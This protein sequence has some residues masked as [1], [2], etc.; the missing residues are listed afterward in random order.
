MKISPFKR[1]MACL[2]AGVAMVAAL[3]P[4]NLW[5]FMFAGFSSFYMLLS[6]AKTPRAAFAIGWLF[7]FGYFAAGL[8]WI[9]NALLVEGNPFAWVWPLAIAGLPAL[10][11]IFPALAA[12]VC[13]R[14]TDRMRLEGFLCFVA[15]FAFSEWLRGHIF[16][17][18]PW[19]LYGYAWSGWLAMAQTASVGGSYFLTLLT[20][21]WCALPGFVAV[22]AISRP[23]KKKLLALGIITFAA[24]A[25]YG[26]FRLAQTGTAYDSTVTLRPVQPNIS[27]ADKW[28]PH[29]VAENLRKMLALSAPDADKPEPPLT[30]IV[31]PETALE[32]E[33]LANED[34]RSLIRQTL[35]QYRNTVYLVTG[36]L[37]YEPEPGGKG[38]YFNSLAVL[39]RDLNIR[40]MFSKSHLVPFGEYIPYQDIIPMKPFVQFQ[41]F[42]PGDG[43]ATLTVDGVPP[44]SPLICYEVVFPGAVTAKERPA[45]MVNVT[46]DAWYGDSPGPR[47]HLAQTRFRAIEEGLPLVRSA[48]T[49]ISG[50]IDPLGRIIY[51]AP[52]NTKDARDISLPKP[53]AGT[54]YASLRDSLFF[55]LLLLSGT[56]AYALERKSRA[57]KS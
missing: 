42:T 53:L 3:P 38:K 32:Y 46:N 34:A 48:E 24:C 43:P 45:W 21:F 50:V 33:V 36:L 18:F 15:A 4:F 10:L 17:G 14:L 37:R 9:A 30:V 8:W 16:T 35:A 56:G 31:W 6:G 44:F 26:Y 52:L 22:S 47:Q 5:P 27:Q 1:S 51:D 19:N 29:K 13:A 28:N 41:G 25:G 23:A 12:L 11:A 2:A 7:G 20:L 55:F 40:A 54:L 49:G 57:L 39:D